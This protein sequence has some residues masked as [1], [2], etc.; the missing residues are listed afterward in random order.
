VSASLVPELAMKETST[1][2]NQ[3]ENANTGIAG[4]LIPSTEAP[5][6]FTVN[7][8]LS[9]DVS[10]PVFSQGEVFVPTTV[11]PEPVRTTVCLP[12]NGID[13]IG[14]L[15]VTVGGHTCLQWASREAA[16]LS[17]SKDFIPEVVLEGNKC[18]NPDN[19]PEGPWCYVDISG[20][21]TIDYCDLELCGTV[22]THDPRSHQHTGL[23]ASH[24]SL[25]ESSSQ[26]TSPW[27]LDSY[28]EQRIVGGNDAEV[29]SAPWFE[30]GIE[31]IVAIDEIIVH[32]KY[33]WKENLNRDIAL[34]H[35]KRPYPAENRWYQIGI[36]SWGE[37][38]DRDGKYGFY[39]HL[40]RMGRWM[41]KVIERSDDNND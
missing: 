36:V 38:C 41:K 14:D 32:P 2:H 8:S 9:K 33:N 15:S 35:M 13:Y 37:G 40:F 27:L 11:A 30:R 29:A 4:S 25:G 10:T 16:A 5:C 23:P 20:N 28:R 1:S 3:A 24:L 22:Q 18:R 39:T 6:C 34:L 21:I 19:D 17:R 31:K 12:S 26:L 7:C